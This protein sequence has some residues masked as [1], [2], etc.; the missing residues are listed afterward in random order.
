[1]GGWDLLMTNTGITVMK[2]CLFFFNLT[3]HRAQVTRVKEN[4]NFKKYQMLLLRINLSEQ[5]KSSSRF[6]VLNDRDPDSHI[7]IVQ[8]D[9]LVS[10]YVMGAW[11]QFVYVSKRTFC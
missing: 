11:L 2:S 3:L 8:F 10:I 5:F 4:N 1:M 7:C 6:S 9:R